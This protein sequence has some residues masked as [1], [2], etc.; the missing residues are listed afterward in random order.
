MTEQEIAELDE[1]YKKAV[2]NGTANTQDWADRMADSKVGVAGY[3][4]ALRSAQKQLK[5]SMVGLG[6]SM[7]DGETGA[8]VFNDGIKAGADRLDL[9]FV[10]KLGPAGMV[11]GKMAQAAAAYIGA[12]NKQ[13]DSLYK[14]FQDI[15][16]TGTIGHSAMRDVY[17]NMQ[18]FGYGVKELD[19]FGSLMA[20]NSQTL[21]QFG[22]NAVDG[23]KAF[24]NM[25]NDLQHSPVTEQLLNMGISVDEIN[26][27]AAGFI[28]QQASLGRGQKEIGDKLASGTLAYINE[29]ENISRLT[30]QTRKEQ[31]DKIADAMAEQAFN[32][33]IG[34][35]KRQEETGDAATREIARR[36]REKLEAGNQIFQGEMRKEFIRGAAGDVAALGTLTNL[37]G[38]E[39][40]DAITNPAKDIGDVVGSVVNGFDR[41]NESG[42]ENLAMM[43]A[44]N[45]TFPD[46]FESQ[47]LAAQYRGKNAKAELEKAAAN[48]NATDSATKNMTK[49]EIAERKA[50]DNM[51]D[52]INFGINPVTKVMEILAKAIEFLTDLLP[53]AG[54]AREQYEMEKKTAATKTAKVIMDNEAGESVTVTPETAERIKSNK[55]KGIT[56]GTKSDYVPAPTVSESKGR[57]ETA[58]GGKGATS[59][60]ETLANKI[61]SAESGGRN[62]AN[63]SGPGGAATSSAFGLFQF[64]KG[65][66]EGLAKNAK[67]GSALYGKTFD[68]YKKDTNLQREA[69]SVLMDQNAAKLSSRGLGTSDANMY[70]AHF[71]GAG[72]AAK[73]LGAG[74][75]ALLTDVMSPEQLAANPSLKSMKTVAD[76]QAWAEKKMGGAEAIPSGPTSGYKPTVTAATETQPRAELSAPKVQQAKKEED[77]DT[78]KELMAAQVA[79]MGDIVRAAEKLAGT[80]QKILQRTNA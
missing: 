47:K 8:A 33:K 19:K 68:D 21:A 43:N 23:A 71:L 1:A 31:E 6:K 13:A 40:V 32:A 58:A 39:I 73:A 30:G 38:G 10:K 41:L 36:Q 49:A 53:G 76:L 20:E 29:L 54:K 60:K 79:K 52:F 59:P 35:L 70:L 74:P 3:T 44:W 72:G 65:T 46:Y 64:T 27:G 62:I 16:R 80:Q 63:Q 2:L 5:D 12:V 14:S 34:Q 11:L 48:K 22:G 57:D 75:S 69:M 18:K 42:G 67:E 61:M 17:G 51:Q 56:E 15:S 50:R 66:F 26:R 9:F 28:K 78:S 7:M 24:A 4:A 55:A 77:E 37:A 25:A 45:G